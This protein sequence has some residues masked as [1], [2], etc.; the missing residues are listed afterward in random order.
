MSS[1]ISREILESSALFAG[2]PEAALEGL[3]ALMHLKSLKKGEQL[4]SQG[5][6]PTGCYAVLEGAL[7]VTMITSE[8]DEML[9]AVLAGGDVTGE[10][11]LIDNAPRCATVTALKPCELAFLPIRDFERFASA[12]PI[13][14][15]HMLKILCDRLRTSNDAFA[16]H[17]LLPLNG[18]LARVLLRLAEGFGQVLDGGRVLIR[19]NFTQSELAMMTGSARENVSRQLNDWR[20]AEVL[21][22]ISR[23]YCIEDEEVLRDLACL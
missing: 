18:R 16:A 12:H 14:Y 20:R 22:K 7:T 19:Q 21:S 8:G 6:H 17:Q 2:L 1:T 9:L 11:G 23:Y 15:R 13:I 5:A 4:F 10:M 3:A